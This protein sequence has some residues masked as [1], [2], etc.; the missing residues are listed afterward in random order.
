L[1]YSIL[2]TLALIL[3]LACIPPATIVSGIYILFFAVIVMVYLF[4][5]EETA[6]VQSDRSYRCMRFVYP[7]LFIYSFLIMLTIYIMNLEFMKEVM[8]GE[9]KKWKETPFFS[10]LKLTHLG[11]VPV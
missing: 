10:N 2:F 7:F 6:K 3:F 1:H 9:E 4:T 8:M 5:G 11:L